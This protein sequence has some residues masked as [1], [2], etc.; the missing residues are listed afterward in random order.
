VTLSAGDGSVSAV[1]STWPAPNYAGLSTGAGQASSE[2]N[3]HSTYQGGGA[4]A[5]ESPE[6]LKVDFTTIVPKPPDS[7]YF[8]YAY[9]M[10]PDDFGTDAQFYVPQADQSA[11]FDYLNADGNWLSIAESPADYATLQDWEDDIQYA[12]AAEPETINGVEVLIEDTGDQKEQSFTATMII[13]GLFVVIDGDHGRDNVKA[14]ALAILDARK[15]ARAADAQ[16]GTQFPA[17]DA[18]TPTP[19]FVPE[20]PPIDDNTT[21]LVILG[22][23]ALCGLGV[24]LAGVGVV[25]AVMMVRRRK[26]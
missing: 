24:C 20:T 6:A 26:G 17:P 8:D 7:Y 11:N 10:T 3:I 12:P 23:M 21:S 9:I 2:K 1:A 15:P 22:A 25:L 14:M 4:G 19:A 18:A 16:G 5:V 13:Q